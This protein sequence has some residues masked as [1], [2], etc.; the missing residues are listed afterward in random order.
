[1]SW[2]D[3]NL[4]EVK[5]TLETLPEQNFKFQ[6]LGASTSKF[7]EEEVQVKAKV[8]EGPF[9]GTPVYIRY[10]SPAKQDW[11]PRVMKRL[12]EK[13]GVE[14]EESEAHDPVSYFNRVAGIPGGAFFVAPVKHR[15]V[16]S[17]TG[18]EITKAEVNIFYVEAA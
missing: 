9:A 8:A 10:P 3:V 1:M 16:Q 17:S 11:S 14:V 2:T 13:L 12:I 6:V 5:T 18:Q 15:K 7:D 4:I